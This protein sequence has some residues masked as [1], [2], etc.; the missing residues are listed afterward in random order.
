MI[1]TLLSASILLQIWAAVWAWLISRTTKRPWGW[2]AFCAALVLMAGRQGVTLG[3]VLAADDADRTSIIAELIGFCVSGL[4]LLALWRM[5]ATQ[6]PPIAEGE[7]AT[8]HRRLLLQSALHEALLCSQHEG[9]LFQRVCDAMTG[10]GAYAG[11]W[12]TLPPVSDALD[13]DAAAESQATDYVRAVGPAALLM[14]GDRHPTRAALADSQRSVAV[15]GEAARGGWRAV[16]AQ[17]GLRAIG[18]FPMCHDDH[19]L[20]VLTV[21]SR[22]ELTLDEDEQLLLTELA[23]QLAYGLAALRMRVRHER[24]LIALRGSREF[25]QTIV[26]GLST[27]TAVLNDSG[28]IVL[29]NEAWRRSAEA[30]ERR[31]G[32]RDGD[33]YAEFLL[34]GLD[35]SAATHAEA[36][37]AELR[38]V[39]AGAQREARFEFALRSGGRVQWYAARITRMQYQRQ[40]GAIVEHADI[41]ERVET[42]QAIRAS[43]AKLRSVFAGVP[44]LMLIHTAEGEILDCNDVVHEFL[45][46]VHEDVVGIRMDEIEESGFGESFAARVQRVRA[47]GRHWY[48]GTYRGARGVIRTVDVHASVIEFEGQDAILT[49]ARDASA[50]KLMESERELLAAAV[51][52]T[53]EGIVITD[54]DG[55]I[56]YVNPAFERTTGYSRSELVGQTPR[57]MKSGKHEDDHYSQ[58]WSAIS[59]GRSWAG[60][61]VNRRRDGELYE[62]ETTIAPVR[63]KGGAITNFVAVKRDVTAQVQ[64][65]AQLRQAQKMEAVGQLAG[66]VAHDFNNVLTAILGNAEMM[67]AELEAELP[68]DDPLLAAL[69]EIERGGKRAA[70]LTRRLLSF[71]RRRAAEPAVLDPRR[72]IREMEQMLRRLIGEHIEL[73]LLLDDGVS[74]VLADA[75]QI[76]QVLLNLVVNARDAMPDGGTVTIRA[77]NV[78]LDARFVGRYP[79]AS[80]GPHVCLEVTDTGCGMDGATRER[81]FEPFF[82]TKSPGRGTGLGLSTVYGIVRTFGGVVAVDSEVGAGARFRVYLPRTDATPKRPADQTANALPSGSGTV[83]VCE[84]EEQ[85]RALVV[86]ALKRAGY[87]VLVAAGGKE[88]LALLAEHSG[89]LDLLLTD[90]IM[91]GM[92]GRAVAEVVRRERP[93]VPVMFMSGYTA[94]VIEPQGVLGEGSELLEKPFSAR[95][96]VERVQVVLEGAR[97]GANAPESRA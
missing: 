85:V 4:M 21:V 32:L 8:L 69:R 52:A 60:H 50:R 49:V 81:I 14:D 94:D 79:D 80:L 54:A 46:R 17:H 28:E 68:S 33:R 90:V 2:V 44:D 30:T 87:E 92:N 66:G 26:D 22:C 62:D 18:A 82:T 65:E 31:T 12:I 45:G 43:D 95:T 61:F 15:L 48:E 24:A 53:G 37:V 63:G 51:E 72:V 67:R 47:E 56:E 11:A 19:I 3:A 38:A 76:E 93:D 39:L 27:H 20:G 5:R 89:R 59:A 57:V 29:S 70:N 74:N 73:R 34:A 71:S 88:A 58:L 1:L 16:S 36:Y 10:V 6:R 86:Q 23:E 42:E 96:L 78:E 55:R 97:S 40:H 91:P 9:E 25:L 84:D 64:L 35:G 41:T 13:F 77:T 83:L 75:S 7:G